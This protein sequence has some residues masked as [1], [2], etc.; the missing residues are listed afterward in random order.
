VYIWRTKSRQWHSCP[1]RVRYSESLVGYGIGLVGVRLMVR[2]RVWCC[3]HRDFQNCGPESIQFGPKLPVPVS[4][5]V[6]AWKDL[7]LK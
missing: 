5:Q 2:D 7:S 1:Y 3:L 4:V 6:I